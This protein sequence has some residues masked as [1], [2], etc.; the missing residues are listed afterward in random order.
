MFNKR[1]VSIF[2]I[3]L[4]PIV[5]SFVLLS[6]ASPN[7]GVTE[8]SIPVYDLLDVPLTPTTEP[9]DG[10]F[11]SELTKSE[12]FDF[13]STGGN[14]PT[15]GLSETLSTTTAI[16]PAT[17]LSS[18]P[19][20]TSTSLPFDPSAII[21]QSRNLVQVT[22][23]GIPYVE[24]SSHRAEFDQSSLTFTI[25][26]EIVSS[27]NLVSEN[28]IYNLAVPPSLTI[29]LVSITMGDTTLQNDNLSLIA[30]E[31]HDNTVRFNK[32]KG[33]TE[34]FVARDAGIE[35]R[36]WLEEKLADSGDLTIIVEVQTTLNLEAT[37]DGFLFYT[38]DHTTGQLVPAIHYARP[39]A[40]DAT[41]QTHWGQ[42][43]YRFIETTREGINHYQLVVTFPTQWLENAQYPLLIDPLISGLLRLEQ[44]SPSQNQ[45]NTQIAYNPDDDEFLLVWEDYRNGSNWDIYGQRLDGDGALLGDNFVI[46]SASYD[47]VLPQVIYAPG[48]D[49]Y[50]VIWQH[51]SS[52]SQYDVYGQL[53]SG[54]GQLVG[55]AFA[56]ATGPGSSGQTPTDIVYNTQS[57]QFLV[58]WEDNRD[59]VLNIWGRH[60]GLTGSLGTET[61]ITSS[62]TFNEMQ[63]VGAYNHDDDQ[64]LVV[65]ATKSEEGEQNL[66]ARRLTGGGVVTT[67][68]TITLTSN[69]GPEVPD[70]V[71]LASTEQ[72]LAVWQDNRNFGSN[73]LDI[74]GRVITP[75]GAIGS[76]DFVISNHSA[77][78]SYPRLAL[79]VDN[80]AWVVWQRNNGVTTGQDLYAYELNSSGQPVGSLVTV[81]TE[82][83]SPGYNQERPVITLNSLGD[84]V[85]AWHD[86]RKGNK[87]IY[88][89]LRLDNGDMGGDFLTHPASDDQENAHV[90][91]NTTEDEYFVVWQDF[92]N[93]LVG[94]QVYGQR[95]SEN[96]VLIG[97]NILIS[98]S[99]LE[100][101]VAYSSNSN[102]YLIVWTYNNEIMG[103]RV[104]ATGSLSGS[105]YKVIPDLAKGE[106]ADQPS[107]VYNSTS[108]LF[109]V[110]L[111]VRTP[112]ISTIH[113]VIARQTPGSYS[114][115]TLVSH[116]DDAVEEPDIAVTG[117]GAYLVVW[118]DARNGDLDIYG[119]QLTSSGSLNGS[120]FAIA[121][122]TGSNESSPDVAW[123]ASASTYL[124]VWDALQSDIN[125]QS[126]LL[127][128]RV[129]T[130]G[131]LVGNTIIFA[132]T[133]LITN[134]DTG[135][136]SNPSVTSTDG[137][138][139]V[140]WQE[141]RTSATETDIKGRSVHSDGVLL[142]ETISLVVHEEKQENAVIMAGSQ[143]F[144]LL[145]WQDNREGGWD[146]YASLYQMDASVIGI[147]A[148]NNS[149]TEIQHTT[150][151]SVTTTS[152][153]NIVYFWTFGDGNIDA[154]QFVTHTYDQPGVYT[155][156]VT[157]T[158]SD[159]MITAT[160][161]VTV[162]QPLVVDFTAAPRIGYA[163]LLVEFTNNSSGADSYEWDFG[164]GFT[165]T[166]IEP[167]HTYSNTGTYAVTLTAT[168]LAGTADKVRTRYITVIDPTIPGTPHIAIAPTIT[169]VD[170]GESFTVT[171][172]IS[173]LLTATSAYQF[174]VVYDDDLLHLESVTSG[175]FL[176]TAWQDT[177]C[178]PWVTPTAN[179]LRLA[180]VSVGPQAGAVGNGLL[181][182][183]KFTALA[184]G[185][186]QLH[187]TSAQLPDTAVPPNPINTTL[188]DGYVVIESNG[189]SGIALLGSSDENNN[190]SANNLL[191]WLSEN[192]SEVAVRT[193]TFTLLGAIAVCAL[194]LHRQKR[195]GAIWRVI[196]V[197]SMILQLTVVIPSSV[198]A[199][200]ETDPSQSNGEGKGL[201]HT[202]NLALPP[203]LTLDPPPGCYDVDVDC[204]KDVDEADV[205]YGSYSWDCADGMSC[206]TALVDLDGNDI[207]DA[208]DL[209]WITNDYDV[210]APEILITNPQEGAVV[211]ASPVQV[212]GII[213]D[214][215][216]ISEVTV[217]GI[218]ANLVDNTFSVNVP[219]QS[220]NNVL[221]V[222]VWDEVGKFSL[223][224]RVVSFDQSGPIVRIIT[225]GDGQAVYT[226][227]PA[228]E[229][230]YG[231]F[232]ANVDTA[233][234]SAI[235][236]DAGGNTIQTI[237][238]SV[239][240]PTSAQFTLDPLSLDAKYTLSVSIA[241]EYGN[242]SLTTNSF[243]VTPNTGIIPPVVPAQPGW[244][245]GRVFDS[246]TCNEHLTICEGIAG[247]EVTVVQVDP[248]TLA[249]AREER[250][251][252]YILLGE[253]DGAFPEGDATVT[254]SYATPITGTA[255]TGP[256]G[257]YAFPVDT[258]GVYHIRIE[259]T[260]F[261][262]GQQE[263]TIVADRS[264]AANEIYL[265]PLDSAVTTCDDGG[266]SHTSFDGQLVVEI[267][268]G[269]IPANEQ[270]EVTATEF[271]RVYFLP[272]GQLPPNTWETYAF[273]LGGNSDYAFQE[274]ITVSLKN[275]REF[276]PG[277]AIPLG[278]WNQHTLQWEHA[279]IAIVEETGE[280]VVMRVTHFSN[281]DPNLAAIRPYI[282]ANGRDYSGPPSPCSDGESGC[283]ISLKS[284]VVKEWVDLPSVNMPGVGSPPQLIYSTDRANPSAIIDVKLD[285]NLNGAITPEGYLT[286][287]LFIEGQNTDSF[288]IEADMASSGEV[289]RYRFLWDGRNAFGELLSP[290]VYAYAVHIR[291]PYEANYCTGSFFGMPVC[292][293]I[294]AGV[295]SP[296]G[297]TAEGAVDVWIYGETVLNTQT[298]SSLGAG[299][300]LNGQEFLYENEAGHILVSSGNALTQYYF[301]L[302]DLLNGQQIYNNPQPP[303]LAPAS[304]NFPVTDITGGTYVS[305]TIDTNTT[306]SLAQSPYIV[307]GEDITVASSATLTIEPGVEVLLEHGH[308]VIVEGVLD[309]QGTATTPITFT[310]HYSAESGTQNYSES[311]QTFTFHSFFGNF[312]NIHAIAVE[313]GGD[314]WIAGSTYSTYS[315]NLRAI[316]RIHRNLNTRDQIQLPESFTGSY[317]RDIAIDSDGRKW[318]ATDNGVLMLAADDVTWTH[319]TELN[320]NLVDNDVRAVVVD[321]NGTVWFAI[322]DLGSNGGLQSLS[323]SN[324]T[325]Y[326]TGDGLPSNRA[327]SLDTDNNGNLWIGTDDGLARF[328]PGTSS[329]TTYDV[330]DMDPNW[331]NIVESLSVDL[332]GNIWVTVPSTGIAMLTVTNAT[333][334]DYST[335]LLGSDV[336]TIKIDNFGRKWIGYD[337]SGVSVLSDDNTA[338]DHKSEIGLTTTVNDMAVSPATDDVWLAI[339]DG[340]AIRNYITGL[341][342]DGTIIGGYWGQL[343]INGSAELEYVT[344]EMGGIYEQSTLSFSQATMSTAVSNVTV[345]A[346]G[347][348]GIEINETDLTLDN[349]TIAANRGDGLHVEDGS[350]VELLAV[351]SQ[352]NQQNG[353]FIG[354][355]S[356]VTGS[357]VT[358][359]YNDAA[360]FTGDASASVDLTGLV[361]EGNNGPTRLPINTQLDEVTWQNNRHNELEWLGGTITE[362]QTWLTIDGVELHTVLETITVDASATLTLPPGTIFAFAQLAGLSITGIL[363]AVGTF[364]EPID[365]SPSTPGWDGITLIGSG[366]QLEYVVIQNAETGLTVNGSSLDLSYMTFASN[367]I[368]IKVENGASVGIAQSNFVGNS[369]YAIDNDAGASY[370]VNAQ[371]N[372]WGDPDGPTH[373]SNPGGGGDPVSD[374]VDFSSWRAPVLLN[375]TA[376]F[377]ENRTEIDTSRLSFDPTTGTYTRYYVDGREVHF[378]A[379]DRHDYTLYPDGGKLAYT[380]NPDGTT[381]TVEATA[382]GQ[383]TPSAVWQFNYQ[384]GQLDSIVDPAGREIQ[385]TVDNNNQLRQVDVPGM[386]SR[387]FYYN[388]QNL[389]TQQ[390]D[391]GGAITSYAYNEYGRL[392]EHTDPLR[393]VY[394]PNTQ[395]TTLDREIMAFVNSDTSYDLI[396]DSVVGDPDNPAPAVPGTDDLEEVVTYGIGSR[397]T[398]TNEWGNIVEQS[399]DLGHTV[400]L[401]RNEANQVTRLE[402]GNGDC[403]EAKHDGYGSVVA[404]VRMPAS[405]CALDPE[406]RDPDLQQVTAQTYEPRYQKPK[407]Q[408]DNA[409]QEVIYYYDYELGQGNAGRVVRIDY[410]PIPNENGVLTT[411][412][413]YY[414][415][416]NLGLLET[417]T[418]VRG[419][420]TRYIYTQGTPDEAAGGANP[421]F[422]PGV[423][424]MAGYL[425]QIIQDDGGFEYTTI[426]KGFDASGNVQTVIFPGGLETTAL[427]DSLGR[428]YMET[429][430]T[431]IV[432]L[433]EYND[434]G[435][436][437]RQIVDYTADGITGENIVTLYEYD[438]DGRLV[439]QSTSADGLVTE[440]FTRYDINGRMVSQSDGQGNETRNIYNSAGQLVKTIDPAGNETRY[441]YTAEGLPEIVI[442]AENHKTKTVY[443]LFGRPRQVI[444]AFEEL[445]LTTTYTYTVA[446]LVEQVKSPDGIVTC[447]EYDALQRRTQTIQD[448][449]P[450]G[451]NLTTQ[452]AYDLAGNTV[453]VTDMRGI[454]TYTEYNALGRVALTRQDD[455]GLDYETSTVYDA[456]TGNVDYTIGVDGTRTQNVYDSFNRLEQICQDSTGLNLCTSYS[457]DR[458]SRQETVTDAEGIVHQTI[459]NAFG[460]PVQ[461]IA[462]A[463]G[464]AAT[465][466]YEYD[467]LMNTV[468]VIDA[469]GNATRYTY[470]N[471]QQLETEIYADGTDVAYTYDPRGNV[472]TLTLADDSDITYSYDAANRQTQLVFSSGGSQS[473][474]YDRASR[475]KKATQ[476]LNG[477]TVITAYGYNTVGDVITTTQQLDSGTEWLTQYEYDYEQGERT[478]TYPSGAVRT[479]SD[480]VLNRLDTVED[481]SSTVI[482]DYD[483][484]VIN[485]F[486]TVAY[487]NGLTNRVDYDAVGRTEQVRVNDGANDI[488]D[489]TY[490]YDQVGNRTYMQRNHQLG[491][492][493]DVYEYDRLYQLVNIWYGADATTP[494]AITSYESHEGY[495]LDVL[496]NRLTATTDGVT[497]TYGPNDGTKLT[498]VMNQYETAHGLPLGYDAKGNTLTDGN[499]VYTYDI[500]NRQTSVT[501]GNGTTEYIYDARGRRIAKVNGS[502]TTHYIYDVNYRIIEERD[503]SEALVATYTYGVGM[504]EPL[505]M[506]RG[507]QIYYYHR[508]GL[509]SITEVSNSVG[510]IVERY[511]Y[512]V[513]GTAT[514]Y[515]GSNNVLSASAIGNPYLFTAREYDPESGNY[516]YRARYYSHE[517]GRFLSRDPLGFAAGDYNLYR[518]VFNNSVTYTD[519]TGELAFI[520]LVILAAVVTLKVVDYAW[521]AWDVYQATQI[522]GDDC[523][524]DLDKLVAGFEIALA[525]IFELIEPDDLLPVSL[526]ADDVA[527]RALMRE[528]REAARE[529][530]IEGF[531]RVVRRNLGDEGA[532]RVFREMGLD[533]LVRGYCSFSADTLVSSDEGLVAISTLEMGDYVLAYDE[534]TGATDYYP[535]LNTLVHEDPVI[536]FLTI[537]GET[538]ETTPEHPFFTD[539]LSQVIAGRLQV[540][541]RIQQAD[542]NYG[543]VEAVAF[544]YQP[545]VMYNLT[546]AD[547]H[548]YFVGNGQWLVHNFCR[549]I[550]GTKG[551]S[552][553]FDEHST[554]WFGRPVG[555][556]THM[557]EWQRLIERTTTSKEIFPWSTGPD[558]TVAHI[559]RID[560]KYFVVQFFT[561][562]ERAGELATAFV[563]GQSQLTAMLRLLGK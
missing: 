269:A 521:T 9:G 293:L 2:L 200:N 433:Y 149:P 414:T 64:Y 245:M 217:N 247:A 257:F 552:H 155:A 310:A 301:D 419:T 425:T 165:S 102:D 461:E 208:F 533:D 500:L 327:L 267:P 116:T 218:T 97:D 511:E 532:D 446:G 290:G 43:D 365:F 285:V 50:L 403:I 185:N 484:D 281:F 204:D 59:G 246:S 41:N 364:G 161:V 110:A 121:S 37:H 233:S 315:G 88:A 279:G 366:S 390:K 253:L 339:D 382:P 324:W 108:N 91:Y 214:R 13:G 111:R 536:V 186:S 528:A 485:R 179:S 312:D 178:P 494:G 480:D 117:S 415:Y 376:F 550:A 545:Q 31:V 173:G 349:V 363:I 134:G 264:T 514:I 502:V 289:G 171:I 348:H 65:W 380:Y 527:R 5:V 372:Y 231:D 335:E 354:A 371:D 105:A 517:L 244:V 353:I 220:G 559:A 449:G 18:D 39:L 343:K 170:M 396:N 54:I 96:G 84:I 416:N 202:T 489:Y 42:T 172:V 341:Y 361:I 406:E 177:L 370:L 488:V 169:T 492:P 392:I 418:D 33:V 283:F 135:V 347:G 1:V 160:T 151:F 228:V 426:Y 150:F 125:V 320:S 313:Q 126:K 309:A 445:N 427:F 431:G 24:Q 546:V 36:W 100:P 99:G 435:Q 470:T 74:Y 122:I 49:K 251:E 138:W 473:F 340:T 266:C 395:T 63:G 519:P 373:S 77:S 120:N 79:S 248:E 303:V 234:F 53:L 509:G 51:F 190:R 474:T 331:P 56:I 94:W 291:I 471:L 391:E 107:V 71:Y 538:I 469:N 128:Q 454:V 10:F 93:D 429:N 467:T 142:G 14:N 441:E 563:P 38:L 294:P 225:P 319:Y 132:T 237:G 191:A 130:S 131:N 464:V 282:T 241:D 306:W 156:I 409:G 490:G 530:G 541:D 424:P 201:R 522:L 560:G 367:L 68:D 12:A 198:R 477:H 385:F 175:D 197:V 263:V 113:K 515:D 192:T 27:S 207:I 87:D 379:N 262:Y 523:A 124:V 82:A 119:Q 383:S 453:Y 452:Y 544:V 55:T 67:T 210:E 46:K 491:Q 143:D 209:A 75:T 355:D 40:I 478:V 466:T 25:F 106:L 482:A 145:A 322:Y 498:N 109:L 401:D 334:T 386:G 455:G 167:T 297:V 20:L 549:K 277:T 199:S 506:E 524:A 29:D 288:T 189:G 495:D 329:W 389:L 336:T 154:G 129:N 422:L 137:K 260:G 280:W 456:V 305:G 163:P 123:N 302:Q 501:N 223:A 114:N 196:V 8:R 136:V 211:T 510:V 443:D 561:Y 325:T 205:S 346:S 271:D 357:D 6:T 127:G 11:T 98:T 182:T 475:M 226:N 254:Q 326:D 216:E 352:L 162:Y 562:G 16:S 61:Q 436:V 337:G 47:Q 272:S 81:Y 276:T 378:D 295:N 90:A 505:T 103:Q 437:T 153:T 450:D 459:Y 26:P 333:W 227:Q 195:L 187:L 481:G 405:Q 345:R 351:T 188:V 493:V 434:R 273:N 507:G 168:G 316:Q 298:D 350:V 45:Q 232:L 368:G 358:L 57:S 551:L 115:V 547:A 86:N 518:Y 242:T 73:G 52:G 203:F 535:V 553:S 554:Q 314:I 152:G 447:F 140:V 516:Y 21:E 19:E 359:S 412:S 229:V 540:G 556:S 146:L 548:T 476:V 181:A 468:R 275:T 258:T 423:T 308:N 238:N 472:A 404:L 394:D 147:T 28:T 557:A 255:L 411:P 144:S 101:D 72:Y 180:C 89:R 387:L 432:T 268:A 486:N 526:P 183:L 230:E 410:P 311:F 356:S 206:F 542:G 384:A 22:E 558:K 30:P 70:V 166:E 304:A 342:V 221:D 479:Y 157:A 194:Y 393:E 539:E 318:F 83:S 174:D 69:T 344:L 448:C 239:A 407:V 457:Y 503:N 299:W 369:T 413:V 212:T 158:N 487:P 513:Y 520:P 442:D 235:I 388:E 460:L 224:S 215:H 439:H 504:D 35:Q 76:S 104:T 543:L 222:A 164:D 60:V 17:L 400:S 34:E 32:G 462:D 428:L 496:G 292:S 259:K 62:T 265:T 398:K 139:L 274:P 118:Q 537:D 213:T 7:D 256:D 377:V 417:E 58:L 420:V 176:T 421:L 278:Y 296:N 323:G 374:D 463:D 360:I 465:V 23:E 317:I 193:M 440:T 534:A 92:R 252:E 141:E 249:L 381:A 529:E 402:L 148:T 362:D 438:N 531:E 184:I 330:T 444:Q 287:E 219:V 458:L 451:L 3:L 300:T 525:G 4:L 44:G 332:D 270:V 375:N 250:A 512:D 430:A 328:N 555:R 236:K 159:N 85:F 284:G 243:Y 321:T 66:Y 15:S 78:E 307:L 240:G 397:T 48:S 497:Q 508:D 338:W 133:D 286:W 499:S 112:G 261:T 408:T 483:Y 95:V 80:G 399:D